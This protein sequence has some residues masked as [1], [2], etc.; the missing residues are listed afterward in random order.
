MTSMNDSSNM[1]GPSTLQPYR[2][3]YHDLQTLLSSFR[4]EDAALGE[5]KSS[6]SDVLQSMSIAKEDYSQKR[7]RVKAEGLHANKTTV[8]TLE[9]LT[10]MIPDQDGLS[11]LR[12]GLRTVFKVSSP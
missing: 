1:V 3:Q 2:Q 12:G 11:V 5:G 4:G 6:W 10:D 8:A 7:G 9:M